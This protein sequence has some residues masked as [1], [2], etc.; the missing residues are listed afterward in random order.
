MPAIKK[1]G[2]RP[3]SAW[4]RRADVKWPMGEGVFE[5]GMW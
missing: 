3:D 1:W 4:L 5:I 2:L